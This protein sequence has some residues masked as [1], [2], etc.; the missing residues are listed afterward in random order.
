[1]TGTATLFTTAW[2]LGLISDAGFHISPYL[3]W[4]ERDAI[5]IM[6][7]TTEPVAGEVQ[8]GTNPKLDLRVTEP[9]PR[10]VHEVRLTGLLPHTRYFYRVVSGSAV[11]ELASFRTPPGPD[12]DKWRM[13][14]Y[15][16][17]RSF[18]D[19]HQRIVEL[20]AQ[21]DPD[22]VLHTG[23]QVTNGT[24]RPQ[25]K[26]Q[27]FDP[28]A[29]LFSRVP[30]LTSLGNHEQNAG[31][32]Y[33]YLA[34]PGKEQYFSI[35]FGSA[36]II[37]LDSN[38]WGASAR[39]SEQF[40]FVQEDLTR[41]RST[42]WNLVFFHHPLFSSHDKR[43]INPAR[44]DWCPLFEKLDM[45]LVL[46]GHDHFYH[47]CWNIGQLGGDSNRG[48]LHLTTAG[49][50]ASLYQQKDRSYVA[51]RKSVFHI[52]VLDFLGDEIHGQA[53]DV[54]GN[55]IDQFKVTKGSTAAGEFCAYEVYELERAIRQQIESRP[56][57]ELRADE[58][59][60]AVDSE[61]RVPHGF[62]VPVTGHVNWEDAVEAAE[63]T[64]IPVRLIPGEPAVILLKR[65]VAV[66]FGPH[67]PQSDSSARLPRMRLELTDD[68][69][70]NR[71]VEFSPLK[72]WRNLEVRAVAEPKSAGRAVQSPREGAPDG[73]AKYSMV[74][75]DGS[76]SA[77][78]PS[79][80]TVA[81]SADSLTVTTTIRNFAAVVTE[82]KAS[83]MQGDQSGLIKG[84]N[85][86][87]LVAT[88]DHTLTFAGTNDG[89]CADA[90]NGDWAFS[91]TDWSATNRRNGD[92]WE[93]TVM[94][95]RKLL[96]R[97]DGLRL[98]VVHLDPVK[99]I[100]DCLSPT[101][102]VG[103]DPDRVPD[104]RFGDRTVNRFARLVLSE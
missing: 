60:T 21:F 55:V 94:I 57:T 11:S 48:V 23:D 26:T 30:V 59:E 53:V 98:N 64:K 77:A 85:I 9:E 42:R 67:A 10:G 24:Q 40:R 56:P 50:G 39:A 74:R 96:A 80:I 41:K 89:R 35:D 58:K 1:M 78:V 13:V 33:E 28:A 69:F 63:E 29:K 52:T 95:P 17:S 47:R 62:R 72:I 93:L 25:W 81:N 5:T 31:N 87:V 37:A 20:A 38:T 27:F 65:R 104:F 51:F 71:T 76:G 36:H 86:R 82:G 88:P 15:G 54:D 102:D 61:I 43:S 70:R 14:V 3:Q 83:A 79:Y 6:W 44:W 34:L 90:R 22:L 18:P 68:R 46:T 66:E 75:S 73:P 12:S 8:F 7:E 100:E 101:F 49:G 16:D 32:Y 97:A 99:S 103:S 92:D 45:D 84:E 19:R 91:D 2:L 4:P